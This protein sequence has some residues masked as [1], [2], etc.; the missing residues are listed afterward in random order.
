[1]MEHLRLHHVGIAVEDLEPARRFLEDVL[2][3]ELERSVTIPER[4]EALQF[5]R[6]GIGIELMRR[7]DGS[8]AKVAT[9]GHGV[10]H[11][12]LYVADFDATLA[13]LRGRGV[14]TTAP[15]PSTAAG[16]RSYFTRAETSGGVV[17]Q[18]VDAGP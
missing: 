8:A 4:L 2:G 1:M 17:F 18:L 13:W 10:D 9:E 6:A 11:V 5:R 7:L 3:F 14:Q 12:A 16:Y 15:E